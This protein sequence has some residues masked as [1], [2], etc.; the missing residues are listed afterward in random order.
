MNLV[1][2]ICFAGKQGPYD[3]ACTIRAFCAE[4]TRELLRDFLNDN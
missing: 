3:F 4:G 1:A 2:E